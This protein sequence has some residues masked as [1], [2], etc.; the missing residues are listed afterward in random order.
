[1]AEFEGQPAGLLRLARPPLERLDDAGPGAPGDMKARHRIAVAHRVIAAALGP[2]D[3]RKHTM[4]HR[5]Q[6]VA[7]LTG[8]ERDVS[9]RPAPRPVVLVAIETCGAHPVLQRELKTVL[10]PALLRR[11]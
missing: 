6:P 3:H 2:A 9:L 4:P 11:V 7:L 10:E 5:A 8:R 1:M